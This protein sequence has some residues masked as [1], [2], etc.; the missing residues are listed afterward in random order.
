M[1]FNIKRTVNR[2]QIKPSPGATV[3]LAQDTYLDVDGKVTTK[4]SDRATRLGKAGKS[5]P[6]E[7]AK[8]AGIPTGKIGEKAAPKKPAAKKTQPARN[9]KRQPARNKAAKPAASK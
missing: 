2:G 8:A 3:T 4:D 9:K 5:V 7:K 6:A 1:G